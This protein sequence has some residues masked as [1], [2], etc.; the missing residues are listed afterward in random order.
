M[1]KLKRYLEL[2]NLSVAEAA[3]KIGCS[4]QYLHMLLG[5]MKPGK[6]TALKI[7]RWSKGFLSAAD[8]M[9]L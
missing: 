2:Q 8:L 7:E 6:N 5:G 9:G 4:R 3:V 1:K